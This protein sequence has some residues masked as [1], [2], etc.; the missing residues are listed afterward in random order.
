MNWLLRWRLEED[1]CRQERAS[2][3]HISAAKRVEECVRNEVFGF[4][5]PVNS[6]GCAK[7]SYTCQAG[8]DCL[9][10]ATGPDIKHME[11]GKRS[12]D[13]WIDGW[14]DG[15][16]EAGI[17][18]Y[19]FTLIEQGFMLPLLCYTQSRMK[20]SLFCI[21]DVNMPFQL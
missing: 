4:D 14:I 16:W 21:R 19:E 9:K 3:C 6:R 11:K 15:R 8:E 20:L 12:T 2:C 17:F 18:W 1:E 13:G 7:T 5:C 10:H